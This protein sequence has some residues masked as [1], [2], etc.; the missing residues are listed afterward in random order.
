MGIPVN[1]LIF[2]DPVNGKSIAKEASSE[3]IPPNVQNTYDFHQ[4]NGGAFPVDVIGATASPS[5]P[6]QN[7]QNIPEPFSHHESMPSDVYSSVVKI[8]TAP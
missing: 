1:N 7:V 6:G 4:S 5:S 8:L 3:I 2:I